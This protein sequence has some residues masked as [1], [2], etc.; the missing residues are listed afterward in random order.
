MGRGENGIRCCCVMLCYVGGE[1]MRGFED[2]EDLL[3]KKK[4]GFCVDFFFFLCVCCV[5]VCECI[6]FGLVY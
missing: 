4:S 6:F 1:E 3:L 2:L 5:F